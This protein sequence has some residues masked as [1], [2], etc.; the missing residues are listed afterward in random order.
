MQQPSD[1]FGPLTLHRSAAGT[2]SGG[3]WVPGTVSSIL[4][5]ACVQPATNRELM[6]L[7]EGDRLKEALI[8]HSTSAL[9]PGDDRA[10][11]VGDYIDFGGEEW[12][13]NV[14]QRF[15][16]VRLEDAHYKGIATRRQ[17]T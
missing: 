1:T 5:N 15:N 10:G 2:Y 16:T 14:V 3:R 8:I 11:L 9:V 4:I 6:A 7:E 17:K 13:I 12:V